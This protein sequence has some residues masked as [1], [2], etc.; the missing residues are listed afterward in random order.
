MRFIIIILIFLLHLS[1]FS[2]N[3]FYYQHIKPIST[4]LFDVAE[5]ENG[6]LAVGRSSEEVY[7][8]GFLLFLNKDGDLQWE[9]N[10]NLE[11]L[12]VDAFYY[13]SIIYK[14]PYFY[15]IGR[16]GVNGV[17]KYLFSKINEQG[18]IVLSKVLNT[19]FQLGND[20]FPSK[21]ILDGETLLI[22]GS[23]ITSTGT[24]GELLKLDL[25]GNIIWKEK[26]SQ[27]PNS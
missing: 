12:L 11:N 6:Y 10:V 3:A 23:G 15:A 18:E 2:Q 17:R 20:N 5:G 7:D 8:K 26:Y 21:I 19:P 4:N 9:K 14:S 25:E 16:A 1:V 24:K 22:A 27:Y 13:K